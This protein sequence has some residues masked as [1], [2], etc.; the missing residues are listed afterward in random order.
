MAQILDWPCASL[1]R[2]TGEPSRID[3]THT[4]DPASPATTCLNC[5]LKS[6]LATGRSEAELLRFQEDLRGLIGNVKRAAEDG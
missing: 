6:A 5:R 2:K 3:Q 1:N 4:V